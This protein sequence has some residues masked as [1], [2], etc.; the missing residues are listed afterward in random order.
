MELK[1]LME[2]RRRAEQATSDMPDGELKLKAFEV[3]L[4][5]L[6][7]GNEHETGESPNSAP[8]VAPEKKQ[9]TSRAAAP[10][11]TRERILVL[12]AEN[13][14][15]KLRTIGEV[16]EQLATRGWH[17]PLTS[18]SGPLQQLV[19]HE[20]RRQRVSDGSTKAWKYSN[21]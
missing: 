19:R 12:K 6:L 4:S 3:I 1:K 15:A 18:L 9:A 14:F 13:F 2:L 5:S 8:T 20:L 17:Y 16:R 10:T 11:S 7:R 21:P